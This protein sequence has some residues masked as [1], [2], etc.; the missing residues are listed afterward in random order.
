[1]DWT[2]S[3][4]EFCI[5]RGLLGQRMISRY[6]KKLPKGGFLRSKGG[7]VVVDR[8]FGA[9]IVPT[10]CLPVNARQTHRMLRQEKVSPNAKNPCVYGTSVNIDESCAP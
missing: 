5:Y 9:L 2:V 6:N 8:V 1:M 10:K 4:R 3:L 7:L